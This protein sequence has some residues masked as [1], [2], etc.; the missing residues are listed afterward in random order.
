MVEK[1]LRTTGLKQCSST[2]VPWNPS[3]PQSM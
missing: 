1:R 3:V 2:W